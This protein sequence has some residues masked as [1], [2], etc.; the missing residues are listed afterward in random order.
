[1]LVKLSLL[2]LSFQTLMSVKWMKGAATASAATPSAATTASVPR[3]A[4][5][6]PTAGPVRVRATAAGALLSWSFLDS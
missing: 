1:M 3:A 6:G 4:D 5:W 2:T